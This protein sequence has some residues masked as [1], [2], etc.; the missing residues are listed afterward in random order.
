MQDTQ[1]TRKTGLIVLPSWNDKKTRVVEWTDYYPYYREHDFKYLEYL[2]K[3]LE[4]ISKLKHADIIRC[5]SATLNPIH[6]LDICDL[7]WKKEDH[8]ESKYYEK[9]KD[10]DCL[11]FCGVHTNM[12]VT[13]KA[14]LIAYINTI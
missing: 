9:L 4:I 13:E 8:D 2:E 1:Q 3:S 5:H 14:A 12:C 7:Y 6:N 11:Y 10:Y